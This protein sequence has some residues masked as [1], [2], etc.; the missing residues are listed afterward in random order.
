MPVSI[1]GFG[2][3]IVPGKQLFV[4]ISVKMYWLFK[5]VKC[6]VSVQSDLLCS[7]YFLAIARAG[8]SDK[9][10]KKCFEW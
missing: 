3:I 4:T 1:L 10:R 8:V 2:D 7:K 5:F 9:E 6:M